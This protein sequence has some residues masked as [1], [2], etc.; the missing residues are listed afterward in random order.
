MHELRWDRKLSLLGRMVVEQK[1]KR[2]VLD[3]ERYTRD[4]FACIDEVSPFTGELIWHVDPKD[5]WQLKVSQEW[6]ATR[7]IARLQEED[8]K[9]GRDMEYT[10]SPG[11]VIALRRM[12]QNP[13]AIVLSSHVRAYRRGVT[14][15]AREKN[16][17]TQLVE[18]AAER[19]YAA[20]K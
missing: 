10:W 2:Y 8:I 12:Q 17:L 6:A 18:H 20:M 15:F 1:R 13:E 9:Q 4:G 3:Y 7:R 16:L 14:I 19:Q 5:A 11:A